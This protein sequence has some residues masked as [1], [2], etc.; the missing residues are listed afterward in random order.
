VGSRGKRVG[1]GFESKNFRGFAKMR[2]TW[3]TASWNAQNESRAKPRNEEFVRAK[4]R[5][6]NG[7]RLPLRVG[8]RLEDLI[9]F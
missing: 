9:A 6:K 5:R 1:E 8:V 4:K 3:K 7:M 2:R